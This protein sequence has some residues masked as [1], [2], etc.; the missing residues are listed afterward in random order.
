MKKILVEVFGWYGTLAIVIAYALN[1]FSV[2][3]SNS[4]VY[5]SLNLTGALGIVAIS[6]YK[7]TYQPGVLNLV[8]ALIAAV[9][10]INI[11]R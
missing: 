3:A 5:Q 4:F 7:K 2:L 1:S 9:T 8:W 10:I 6:F 11:L